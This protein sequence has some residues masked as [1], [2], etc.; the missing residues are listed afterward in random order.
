MALAAGCGSVTWGSGAGS[1][2][3]RYPITAEVL[4]TQTPDNC[5][6][7]LGTLQTGATL[8]A[9][10]R[11]DV[12][13]A[14]LVRTVRK[15]SKTARI[16]RDAAPPQPGMATPS[17]LTTRFG[18]PAVSNDTWTLTGATPSP[19][20]SELASR[21]RMAG[22]A[23]SQASVAQQ[24]CFMQ[25]MGGN[26]GAMGQS[27]HEQYDDALVDPD[28]ARAHSRKLIGELRAIEAQEAALTGIL[29]AYE[30]ALAGQIDPDAVDQLAAKL[31]DAAAR[32]ATPASDSDVASVWAF[33]KEK[34]DALDDESKKWGM[35][36]SQRLSLLGLQGAA[37]RARSSAGY[38]DDQRSRV[39]LGE[40]SEPG[41]FG[42][43]AQSGGLS[44]G[45]TAALKGLLT[46][47]LA[48]VVEGA[49]ELLPQ[50][51]PFVVGLKGAAALASG[52]FVTAMKQASLLAPKDSALATVLALPDAVVSTAH[53]VGMR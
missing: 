6:A 36:E 10:G 46:G 52:D 21:V 53:S 13:N 7:V 3:H 31:K 4:E 34:A 43:L 50:D 2:T 44:S 24:L 19:P 22:A 11:S 47:N 28:V 33:A 40:A 41:S 30:G 15:A 5:A 27:L 17:V 39:P 25:V 16:Q 42:A 51:N 32:H 45:I 1:H 8:D 26:L 18:A 9:L 20:S 37:Y 14:A 12:T 35:S 49:A 23:Y 48:A 38:G 29:A